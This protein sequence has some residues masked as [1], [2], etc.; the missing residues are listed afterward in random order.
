MTLSGRSVAG[1]FLLLVAAAVT[2]AGW[3]APAGYAAQ[4]RESPSLAPC[5]RYPLGTDELGRDLFARLLYG[6]RVSLLLAGGAAAVSTGIAAIVGLG[7]G[8]AGGAGVFLLERSSSL[9]LSLPWLFLLLAVRSALPL[10]TVPETSAWVTFL[11]LALLGWAAPAQV[12]ARC[13]AA[14][15]RSGFALRARTQGS[16]VSRILLVQ[17]LPNLRPVV[18]SQFLVLFPGFIL[19]EATLSFL[20]LGVAE[21]LPS[22]GGLL[23]GLEDYTAVAASPWKLAPLLA[24][25]LVAAAIQAAT[26]KKETHPV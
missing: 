5:R 6:G 26:G 4:D 18:V 8:F 1:A 10:D 22:W 3:L 25:V 20:G 9:L 19:T 7:A 13:A 24:L 15:A 12:I 14:L 23:R 11:V 16:G 17:L 21:P 2:L